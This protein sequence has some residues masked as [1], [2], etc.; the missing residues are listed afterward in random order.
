MDDPPNDASTTS[1]YV[2]QE[3]SVRGPRTVL[4]FMDPGENRRLLGEWLADEDY[5][6]ATAETPAGLESEFDLCIVDATHFRAHRDALQDCKSDADLAFLPLLLVASRESGLL[7]RS[8]VWE[9]VDDVVEAPIRQAELD[10]RLASLLRQRT[11]S[12]ELREREAQLRETLSELRIKER[13]IDAAPVGI[14]ICEAGSDSNDIVYVN[15]RFEELTGYAEADVVGRD[16]RLL[17][18]ENTSPE[19]VA[20]L[21]AAIDAERPVSVEL[22]NYEKSGRLFWNRVDVAPVRDDDGEVTRFVGFQTDVTDRKI[23]EQRLTVL[24]RILRHNL[25]NG[26]GVIQGYC[27]LLEQHVSG[28]EEQSYLDAVASAAAD[29]TELSERV[30]D[31]EVVLQGLDDDSGGVCITTALET[32]LS[33]LDAHAP[34]TELDIDVPS[35]P[36]PLVPSN[37]VVVFRELVR[38]AL[39]RCDGTPRRP[40]V[41]IDRCSEYA[42]VIEATI[43]DYS[44]EPLDPDRE[45]LAAGEETPLLHADGIGLWLAN[46]VASAAGGTIEIAGDEADAVTVR[47]PAV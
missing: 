7:S 32:A 28:N 45:V 42:E 35:G 17:Q 44:T 4:L 40:T 39:E 13:A 27:E 38:N 47:F 12:L 6:V 22:Q 14:T 30:H 9:F 3:P 21:R 19:P 43:T 10:A 1:S 16:C 15:D 20:E 33:E 8:E 46:W 26:M 5:D 36:L 37:A 11:Q 2:A 31:T 18:G 23:R 29:L 24:N 41:S 25:R 34:A